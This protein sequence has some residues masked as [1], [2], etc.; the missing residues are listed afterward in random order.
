M[1][2][3][4]KDIASLGGGGTALL[5]FLWLGYGDYKRQENITS[6]MQQQKVYVE[7]KNPTNG[8]TIIGC[9]EIK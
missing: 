5:L 6:C 2:W 7:E 4:I 8:S 9:K 3:S 1:N